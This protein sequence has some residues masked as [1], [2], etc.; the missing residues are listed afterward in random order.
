MLT[1]I[2]LILDILELVTSWRFYL[3]LGLTA[4]LIWLT[5]TLVSN[6]TAR[7]VICLPLAIVGTG[8]G[9]YWEVRSNQR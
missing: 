2:E 8:S 1:V 7:W 4:L 3:T 6:E 9:F 5:I